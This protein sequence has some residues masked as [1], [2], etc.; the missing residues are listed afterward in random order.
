MDAFTTSV[1][2]PK[3]TTGQ[4]PTGDEVEG[5][6][7]YNSTNHTYEFWDGD[8]WINVAGN[9]TTI[10][11][12]SF[13]GDGTTLAYTLSLPATSASIIVS[14]NGVVQIPGTAYGVSGTTL[15]F[16][17]APQIGDEID[18]RLLTTTTTVT[19]ITDVNSSIAISDLA[20]TANVI[21][22]GNLKLS[23]TNVSV[24]PGANNAIT[25]GAVGSLWSTVYAQNTTIQNA[26]LA[27]NYL[28]DTVIPPAT[29]VSF[30]G[31]EEVTISLT[32]MDTRVAGVVSTNPAHVMN[33]FLEGDNVVS[34][35]LQGR[36]PCRVVGPVR[37]GDM[38]VSAGDGKARAEENPKYGSVIGK[39]LENFDGEEGV[40]EVVV[41]RV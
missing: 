21:I 27:E 31:R 35:A 16:T 24:I 28:A 1:I 32:D 23:V 39:A 29:V 15:T 33:G 6:I 19:D 40:I 9:F 7:R 5:M 11:A 12:D 38:M 14:I 10:V 3:G 18:V 8:E 2:L 34:I 17:E 4:R 30:G 26:D 36:V 13:S 20:E 41:G 37:K 25:L 22:N